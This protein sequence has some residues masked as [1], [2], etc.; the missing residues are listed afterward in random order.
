[1]V[2]SLLSKGFPILTPFL[3]SNQNGGTRGVVTSNTPGISDVEARGVFGGW[4]LGFKE[5]PVL[6][7]VDSRPARASRASVAPRWLR[8]MSPKPVGS[9]R[10]G[11]WWSW[12]IFPAFQPDKRIRRILAGLQAHPAHAA[13]LCSPD[14]EP[15]LSCNPRGAVTGVPG[16]IATVVFLIGVHVVGP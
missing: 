1:M 14:D 10:N 6:I 8:T 11:F 7:N 3:R 5:F 9:P 2:I 15:V 13:G 16:G 12:G 4:R